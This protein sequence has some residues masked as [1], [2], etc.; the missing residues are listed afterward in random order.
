VVKKKV[1]SFIA[2]LVVGVVCD[3]ILCC[4]PFGVLGFWGMLRTIDPPLKP[5]LVKRVT[6]GWA[7]GAVLGFLLFY[8]SYI[9]LFA[10]MTMNPEVSQEPTALFMLVVVVFYFFLFVTR[11]FGP[12]ASLVMFYFWRRKELAK[13]TTKPDL[14]NLATTTG[15]R[16]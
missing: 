9:P 6:T 14:I 4:L 12:I 11:F 10:L 7:I 5:E 1:R 3:T 2:P 8:A 16:T 15:T 13:L